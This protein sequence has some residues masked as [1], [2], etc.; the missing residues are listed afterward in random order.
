[1]LKRVDAVA[2]GQLQRRARHLLAGRD[3]SPLRFRGHSVHC[4]VR[5]TRK[6]EGSSDEA[7]RDSRRDPGTGA[8]GGGGSPGGSDNRGEYDLGLGTTK[9]SSATGLRLH[10]GYR[11]PS[12]PGA[13]PPPVTAASFDLPPGIRIDGAA[14]PSCDASDAQLRARGRDACP[15]GSSVGTGTLVAITGFGPPADP[16]EADVEVFNGPN[17]LVEVVFAKDTNTVL[18]MDRV[19]VRGNR[20]IAHP[21]ATPGGPPDGR[22]SI[23]RI[24]LDLPERRGAGG[25]AFVTTP[26]CARATAAG[27]RGRTTGSP[28]AAGRPSPASRR[29]PRP[30]GASAGARPRCR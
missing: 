28:T 16:V 25:R 2:I 7:G 21:P 5:C 6:A 29:A 8:D 1:M 10:V 26:R 11:N 22:T 13:K 9:P 20:L 30:D 18:G 19:D 24:D 27:A 12:D 15:A 23:R 14:V 17:Q 3:G 4:T